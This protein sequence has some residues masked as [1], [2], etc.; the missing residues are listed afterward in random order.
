MRYKMQTTYRTIEYTVSFRVH[1][2][3]SGFSKN[4]ANFQ[5]WVVSS[6]PKHPWVNLAHHP[7]MIFLVYVNEPVNK[8]TNQNHPTSH[9]CLPCCYIQWLTVLI[10]FEMSAYLIQLIS[11]VSWKSFLHL[12]LG[13]HSPEVFIFAG[14]HF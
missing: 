11:S 6:E 5:T 12:F 14:H 10:L 2:W 9:F 13:H 8:L 1:C 7:C 4:R 3:M